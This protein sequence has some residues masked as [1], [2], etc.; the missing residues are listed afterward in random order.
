MEKPW[1]RGVNIAT[2]DVHVE[3]DFQ[4]FECFKYS[5]REKLGRWV[6]A[7]WTHLVLK[8]ERHRVYY[9]NICLERLRRRNSLPTA[10]SPAEYSGF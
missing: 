8:T 2:L 7:T 3:E 5:P 10:E 9:L 6:G 4:G 1:G